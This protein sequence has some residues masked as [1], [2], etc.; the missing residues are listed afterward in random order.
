[1]L[2]A[3]GAFTWRRVLFGNTA[4]YACT[5]SL[6]ECH[7]CKVNPLTLPTSSTYNVDTDA[8]SSTSCIACIHSHK[9]VRA[10]MRECVRGL[11]MVL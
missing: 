10:C 6:H 4:Q 9:Q 11:T 2:R 3:I 5:A 1:M 7:T 8:G